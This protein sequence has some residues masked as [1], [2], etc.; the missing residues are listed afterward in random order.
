MQASAAAISTCE[1]PAVL[2]VP[3]TGARRG[4]RGAIRL[5][6]RSVRQARTGSHAYSADEASALAEFGRQLGDFLE[7]LTP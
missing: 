7:A 3:I 1:H 4:A 2:W 5:D 6:G